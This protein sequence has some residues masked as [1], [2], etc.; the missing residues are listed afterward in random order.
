MVRWPRSSLSVQSCRVCRRMTCGVWRRCRPTSAML[1]LWNPPWLKQQISMYTNSH[2]ADEICLLL[3]GSLLEV[4]RLIFRRTSCHFRFESQYFSMG[5]IFS[6]QASAVEIY[7]T[8]YSWSTGCCQGTTSCRDRL[9]SGMQ[10]GPPSDCWRAWCDWLK[11]Y[12]VCKS[13]SGYLYLYVSFTNG[14]SAWRPSKW[15]CESL[16]VETSYCMV[17]LIIR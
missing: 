6:L 13:V 15:R 16:E 12:T 9:T 3:S 14:H 1:S 2:S 7:H 10:L 8:V 5:L 4:T 11:V 17:D